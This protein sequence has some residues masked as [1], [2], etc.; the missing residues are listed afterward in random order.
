[1][2]SFDSC[3]FFTKST[4]VIPKRGAA[5]AAASLGLARG[6]HL[7][8]EREGLQNWSCSVHPIGEAASSGWYTVKTPSS[9]LGESISTP[10]T[11]ARYHGSLV[12]SRNQMPFPEKKVRRRLA[13]GLNIAGIGSSS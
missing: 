9:A 11:V 12:L 6:P 13:S 8:S 5:W 1:M 4:D 10:G 3:V 7:P 2:V